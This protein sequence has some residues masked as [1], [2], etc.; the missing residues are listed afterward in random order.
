M[1]QYKYE[2]MNGTIILGYVTSVYYKKVASTFGVYLTD[3]GEPN[4][5]PAKYYDDFMDKLNSYVESQAQ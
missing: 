3:N 5:V 1:Y 2:T 4:E